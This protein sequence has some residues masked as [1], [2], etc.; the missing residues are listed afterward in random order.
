MVEKFTVVPRHRGR[1]RRLFLSNIDL[2]LVAF[3]ETVAFFEPPRSPVAL[4]ELADSF[5]ESKSKSKAFQ[6]N[7][8]AF[9]S[10]HW[11]QG[12]YQDFCSYSK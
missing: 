4:A 7:L 6:P 8:Q 1:R 10:K 3:L 5:P 11:S 9:A 12:R 2:T